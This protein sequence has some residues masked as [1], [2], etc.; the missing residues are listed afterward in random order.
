MPE[1]DD[2]S[3]ELRGDEDEPLNAKGNDWVATIV[4]GLIVG[5]CVSFSNRWF[6]SDTDNT[7]TLVEVAT[8][9]EYLAGQVN[10]LTEQP[11]VRRDEFKSGIESIQD[12]VAGLSDRIDRLEGRVAP[13]READRRR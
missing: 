13:V 9:V 3:T 8:K 1:S 11:Y 4:G 2:F 12:S 6:S 7:K 5:V 10:K